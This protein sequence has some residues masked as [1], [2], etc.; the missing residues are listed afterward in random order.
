MKRCNLKYDTSLLVN[1]K[2]IK[3]LDPSFIVVEKGENDLNLNDYVFKNTII[4]KGI[5][6]SFSSISGVVSKINKYVYVSNDYTESEGVAKKLLR[7]KSFSNDEI[8]E[9]ILDFGRDRSLLMKHLDRKKN[10]IINGYDDIPY[11]SYK[12]NYLVKYQEDILSILEVLSD[13]FENCNFVMLLNNKD[14]KLIEKYT[15]LD[16]IYPFLKFRY[17]GGEY[18]L[19][20]DDILFESLNIK[21]EDSLVIN[22][23]K[24]VELY[25]VVKRKKPISEVYLIIN[26]F[27]S[28]TSYKVSVKLGSSLREIFNKLNINTDGYLVLSNNILND[29]VIDVDKTLVSINEYGYSV[30]LKD[31]A[32]KEECINCGKCL[33]VCPFDKCISCGVCRFYCP[34]KQ[35]ITKRFL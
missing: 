16:G 2:N 13:N 28:K 20:V 19:Y 35:K 33:N 10:I 18:P 22:P 7:K 32:V 31:E 14:T 6:N 30:V 27:I 4:N 8:D 24:L 15:N 26:D 12:S 11:M 9:A 3:I 34:T 5:V 23:L 17:F 29:Y 25:S 1:K 21:K